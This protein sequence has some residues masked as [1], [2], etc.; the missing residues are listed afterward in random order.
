MLAHKSAQT[1]QQYFSFKLG[2]RLIVGGY[3]LHAWSS[4]LRIYSAHTPFFLHSIVP[5]TWMFNMYSMLL[6][7]GRNFCPEVNI[8]TNLH[9]HTPPGWHFHLTWKP[10]QACCSF[11]SILARFFFFFSHTNQVMEWKNAWWFLKFTKWTLSDRIT[12]L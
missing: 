4:S 1:S 5:K 9:F 7:H 2:M 10:F 6:P 11:V 12:C 8:F 3:I